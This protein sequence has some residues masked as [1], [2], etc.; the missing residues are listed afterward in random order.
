[1]VSVVT[2]SAGRREPAHIDCS[3]YITLLSHIQVGFL[4]ILAIPAQVETPP[5]GRVGYDVS[6]LNV[7]LI[8]VNQCSILAALRTLSH[9]D[10][11]IKESH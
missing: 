11:F 8:C 7:L 9:H 2:S 10:P 4:K 3:N 5:T 6:L 1:M